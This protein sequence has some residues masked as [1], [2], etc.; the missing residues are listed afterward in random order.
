MAKDID[1]SVMVGAPAVS[2]TWYAVHKEIAASL[3]E[4]RAWVER[5]QYAGRLNGWGYSNTAICPE[6]G[7]SELTGRHQADCSVPR[8]LATN[9]P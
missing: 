5:H 6:C 4:L 2:G 7:A 9:E 8:L 1:Y 3:E